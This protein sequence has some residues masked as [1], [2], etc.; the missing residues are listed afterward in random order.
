LSFSKKLTILPFYIV[1]IFLITGWWTLAF[2][3]TKSE[4]EIILSKTKVIKNK[5]DFYEHL[6]P[7]DR[8]VIQKALSGDF[9][10]MTKL[11]LEWDVDAKILETQGL[12][13]VRRLSRQSY[14]RSQMVGRQLIKNASQTVKVQKKYLPQTYISA[15]FLLTLL[16]T[17][18]IIGLPSGFRKQKGMFAQ[19]LYDQIPLD[20]ERLNSEKIFQNKANLAFIAN[21]SQPSTVQ[22]LQNQG[23]QLF[24]L[25]AF[26][27]IPEIAASIQEIGQ[28]VERPVEAE[29]LTLFMES[30]LIAID[31]RLLAVHDHDA[32]SNHQRIL[33]LNYHAQFSV[34]TARTIT[35]HLLT[36]LMEHKVVFLSPSHSGPSP[37]TTPVDKEK[38]ARCNPE[39]L[40]IAT[41][42]GQPLESS[43]TEGALAEVNA[44]K[45]IQYLNDDI[46]QSNTHYIVLAYFDLADAILSP[47]GGL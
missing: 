39:I 32:E 47:F 9:D 43:L 12:N 5:P 24:T 13:G 30:A 45:N 16:D 34:P 26:N 17:E 8:M 33:F 15:T 38:I 41:L 20:L 21:F 23:I 42:D 14:V 4:K 27:T 29:L 25:N 3:P 36:R 19:E 10:L 28:L 37:W 40:F 46:Q 31:N 44:N 1:V 22:A 11:I 18:Q 35:G 6:A 7:F 2:S